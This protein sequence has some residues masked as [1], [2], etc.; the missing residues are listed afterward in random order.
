MLKNWLALCF[1]TI[2]L[3][4]TGLDAKRV[5]LVV[6]NASYEKTGSLSNP[7][8][9]VLTIA[10]S[11]KKAGFDDVIV[12][13]DL[14]MQAFQMKI[15]EFREKATGADL[16]M[17]YYAGHGVESRGKNWLIPVDAKLQTSLDLP[18]EAINLD[19]ILEA[20]EGSS[21]GM[22]VLDACRN[23]PFGDT[24]RSGSRGVQRGLV[25]VDADDILVIYAAAPGQTADDGNGPNSP[26]ATSLA[27]R[28]VQPDLPIQMLGG[29]IRDDVLSAT[30]GKQRPYVSA[31]ITGTPI[32]LVQSPPKPTATA[33]SA[34]GSAN[35]TG[36]RAR[37]DAL[38]WR[39]A[40]SA[41][42]SSAYSAYL[43]EFP[44]GLFADLA[45][46]KINELR[47]PILAGRT[48]RVAT[49]PPVQ[50][51]Q[52][53]PAP[54]VVPMAAASTPPVSVAA[55]PADPKPT[56][57]PPVEA[58]AP[59][60]APASESSEVKMAR[61]GADL[62]YVPPSV[63]EPPLPSLPPT[64]VLLQKDYPDCK[65]SHQHLVDPLDKAND[66]NACTVKLDQYYE[67]VLNKFREDMNAHQ[68]RISAIY[69]EK[70]AGRM[71]YSAA[72]RDRFYKGMMQE[73][74][75]SNPDGPN[76]AVYRGAVEL[77]ES[78]RNYL[79][80]RFCFNTGCEGYTI[81]ENFG[82]TR[83]KGYEADSDDDAVEV[84]VNSEN[85]TKKKNKK[86]KSG[87]K[88]KKSRGRGALLGSIF[89]G[90]AGKAVGLNKAGTLLA[91]GLGALIVGE[92]ACQL[93]E[94]EQKQAAKATE[95]VTQQE[96]VGATA[97]WKSP[98][99]SGV[100]GSSTV[101]ALNTQPNGQKCLTITDVAFIDGEE[102]RVSKQMC[103][104]KNGG[105]YAI[106]A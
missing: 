50:S 8:N 53:A 78:D 25:G 97:T 103:R 45:K 106:M 72:N 19:R 55:Q 54:P 42:S 4:T 88:C 52:A 105:R 34:A 32:Y 47:Q 93:D 43:T 40:L 67:N 70:V 102:T 94:K 15:R 28:L 17:V 48:T 60:I 26:F 64:P 95:M 5:A 24:W 21:I 85:S 100:S 86:K 33:V 9:D 30:G 79:R 37:L 31:N 63:D 58:P 16:A 62:A 96:K 82:F 80:D 61:S 39:G 71:E 89:G 77:Y 59:T 56:P 69:T 68:D 12:A 2:I 49:T 65:E 10:Q 90:L 41:N 104:G 98:T 1:V 81:P 23:N 83:M 27:K 51:L 14:G 91:S 87:G 6:G 22:V 66:I 7:T 73:H 76:L 46:D 57:R 18:Y 99:R 75:D 29:T 13:R 3:W 84:A 36:N 20:L 92:I 101:T 74:A 38:S 44:D 11:A 35:T